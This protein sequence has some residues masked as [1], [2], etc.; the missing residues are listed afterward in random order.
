MSEPEPAGRTRRSIVPGWVRGA[1][2]LF[3]MLVTAVVVGLALFLIA[4][5]APV[6]A[7]LGWGCSSPRSPRRWSPGWSAAA[8]PQARR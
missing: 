5:L 2:N 6:L 1:S 4:W 8:G 3:A 7:P